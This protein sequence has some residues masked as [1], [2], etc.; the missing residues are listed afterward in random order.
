MNLGWRVRDAIWTNDSDLLI[1]VRSNVFTEEQGVSRDIDCDGRDPECIHFLAETDSGNPI[2]S[3]RLHNDGKVGRVA[4]LKEW[5]RYGVG[6]EIMKN[7]ILRAESLG[8]VQTYLHSQ[9]AVVGFYEFLG[10]IK[11]GPNFDEAGIPHVL[12]TR[13]TDNT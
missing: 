6:A 8:M 13:V 9:V 10:Y 5:R 2:G 7:L 4:V 1:E 3:A 11:E 12:M